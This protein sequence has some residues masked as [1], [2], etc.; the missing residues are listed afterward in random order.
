MDKRGQTYYKGA[1]LPDPATGFRKQI[2]G[3]HDARVISNY[4]PAPG[5]DYP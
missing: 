3:V 1:D 4:W 2:E 5:C